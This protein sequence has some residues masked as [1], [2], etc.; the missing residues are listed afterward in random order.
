M[1]FCK[2]KTKPFS[3][4]NIMQIF[5]RLIIMETFI[6][7]K[8]T[9]FIAFHAGYKTVCALIIHTVYWKYILKYN[10]TDIS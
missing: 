4:V 5:M 8:I 3:I 9:T 1:R 6:K 2:K 7:K 10:E